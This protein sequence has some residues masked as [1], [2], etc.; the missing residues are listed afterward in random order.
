MNCHL[1]RSERSAVRGKMQIPRFARD[2]KIQDLLHTLGGGIP[3][4]FVDLQAE[5]RGYVVGEDPLRELLWIEEAVG[6]VSRAG[7]GLF[8]RGGE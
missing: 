1:D 2:G 3:D 8:E 5:P 7:G 6:S 4:Q